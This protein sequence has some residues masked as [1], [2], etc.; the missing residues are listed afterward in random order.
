MTMTASIATFDFSF[1]FYRQILRFVR[2]NFDLYLFGE[3]IDVEDVTTLNG[4]LMRHDVDI[5]IKKALDIARV[6][7]EEGVK[8]TFFIFPC[9][10]L[11][12]LSDRSNVATLEEI[13]GLGHEVGLHYNLDNTRRK[14]ETLRPDA[15][16]EQIEADCNQ[17]E[18]I[19]K[20]RVRCLSF[21]RPRETALRGEFFLAGRVNAYAKGLMRWYLSDS[22]GRWREGDPIVSL[23]KPK[24]PLLQL[25]THP[26]WWGDRR[27]MPEERLQKFFLEATYNMPADER[28]A[29]DDHLADALSILRWPAFRGHTNLLSWRD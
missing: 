9:W 4:C 19:L 16:L 24:G 10:P 8:S 12:S 29:F 14:D 26:I 7:H 20:T 27:L 28:T 22:R 17:L 11:Y 13:T 23:R 2:S 25:L 18:G 1:E 6:E 5:D 3:L 21:H 15:V